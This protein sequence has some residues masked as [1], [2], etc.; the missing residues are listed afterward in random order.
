MEAKAD[1]KLVIQ[2]KE[3][4]GRGVSVI[5]L[6]LA[7]TLGE[8]WIGSVASAWNVV[9]TILIAIAVIKTFLVV[10]D[11]MH[12]GRLFSDGEEEA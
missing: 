1:D 5:I 7:L 2:K 4:F 10:R 11:Y 9:G 3:A 6:L 8:F 12:I